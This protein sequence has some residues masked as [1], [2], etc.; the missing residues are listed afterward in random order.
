MNAFEIALL[1]VVVFL[2]YISLDLLKTTKTQINL[3]IQCNNR[4]LFLLLMAK[5]LK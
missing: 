1:S 3:M 5:N 2:V 4:N